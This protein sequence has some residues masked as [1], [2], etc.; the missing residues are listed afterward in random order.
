LLQQLK[1]QSTPV[2]PHYLV[3]TKQPVGPNEPAKAV[4]REERLIKNDGTENATTQS[5]HEA[6]EM[7]LMHELK[8]AVCEILPSKWDD[9]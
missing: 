3:K 2:T 7:R 5:Y 4:L 1:A 6:Q 9:K 8:E